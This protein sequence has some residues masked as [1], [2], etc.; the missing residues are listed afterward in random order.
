L[1]YPPLP[2][3]NLLG[4]HGWRRRIDLI[5]GK[6]R[7]WILFGFDTSVKFKPTDVT[8]KLCEEAGTDFAQALKS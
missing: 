5:E 2:T 8:L 7:R 4:F 6:L 1:S 3:T